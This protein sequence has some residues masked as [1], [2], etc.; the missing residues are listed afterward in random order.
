MKGRI[1][2][3]F[4][5]PRALLLHLFVEGMESIAN[6][7]G[8]NKNSGRSERKKGL[9]SFFSF[10]KPVGRAGQGCRG[11]AVVVDHRRVAWQLSQM[12]VCLFFK[13]PTSRSYLDRY[14]VMLLDHRSL[15]KNSVALRLRLE[16]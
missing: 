8:Y 6:N 16:A 5:L 12:I 3:S 7:R 14:Y 4:L 11:L 9:Q 10:N 2:F 13:L 15:F 1:F